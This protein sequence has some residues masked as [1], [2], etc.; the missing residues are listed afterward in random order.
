MF[1]NGYKNIRLQHYDY[2]SGFFFVTNKADFAQNIFRSKIKDLLENELVDLVSKINSISIDYYVVM[3]N[4]IHVIL[5]FRN[6]IL[7]LPEFWRRYKAITTY[8]AKKEKLYNGTLWQRNYFEHVIRSELGLHKIRE[9]IKNNPLKD[10][11]PL[12]ELY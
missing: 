7:A 9:Y 1:V 6:S 12:A 11:L 5:I 3:P 4:H 2:H 8:K 10:S